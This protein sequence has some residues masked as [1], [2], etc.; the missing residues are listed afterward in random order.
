[1]TLPVRDHDGSVRW[2]EAILDF[3]PIATNFRDPD[4][5]ALEPFHRA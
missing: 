1:V 2:Y 3:K 5:I 4:G